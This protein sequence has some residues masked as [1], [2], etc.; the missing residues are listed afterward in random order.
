MGIFSV[1]IMHKVFL[2]HCSDSKIDQGEQT[3]H[4]PS[5]T[6]F[7]LTE[8]WGLLALFTFIHNVHIHFEQIKYAQN[9]NT[10]KKVHYLVT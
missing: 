9:K 4:L 5:L 1:H 7:T 6:L 3:V 10:N 8:F 2:I